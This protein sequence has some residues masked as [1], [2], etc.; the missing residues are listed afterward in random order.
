MLPQAALEEAIE[1]VQSCDGLLVVGSSLQVYP[2]AG[3]PGIALDRGRPLWIVN[4]DPTPYDD[5]AEV[6]IR[7]K[8]GEVLP[9]VAAKLLDS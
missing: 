8:A 5:A 2:A 3:L 9:K 4:L 7:R 6:V 1:A